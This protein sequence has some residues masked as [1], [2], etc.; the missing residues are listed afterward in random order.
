MDTVIQNGLSKIT[1]SENGQIYVQVLDESE[2]ELTSILME[3]NG[4]A[5]IS[6]KSA[7]DIELINTTAGN[8]II[9]NGDGNI[10]IT[11]P[12]GKVISLNGA[13]EVN[14]SLNTN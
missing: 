12:T 9:L 3:A 14:G 1:L 7:N 13:V 2:E 11:A 8:S 5:A 10:S 4:R 6:T